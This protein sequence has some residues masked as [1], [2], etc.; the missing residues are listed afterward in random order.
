MLQHQSAETLFLFSTPV[1]IHDIPEHQSLN[2]ELRKL[3]IEERNRSDGINRS[4]LGGWHSDTN[5]TKWAEAPARVIL[6]HAVKL[7]TQQ[8]SDIRAEGKR[9][10]I[11]DVMMWANINK[12]GDANQ[13]HCH[14]GSLWSGVYYVES[15]EVPNGTDVQGELVL[16]DPR[17]PM[18]TMYMPDLVTKDQNGIPQ[19]TLYPIRPINGRLVLFPSWL[20]HA[21]RPYTG[22]KDRISIAFNLTVHP[23]PKT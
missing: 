12:K 15:G 19:R 23:A 21:V 8:M 20:Q 13:M 11:F 4:N 10:F 16:Q 7:C 14:S 3:I 9:E 6:S 2:Q 5:M 17:F 18:N 1:I 22:E